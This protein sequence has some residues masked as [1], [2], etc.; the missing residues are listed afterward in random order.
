MA[1]IEWAALVAVLAGLIVAADGGY[2]A[3]FVFGLVLCA[4]ICGAGFGLAMLGIWLEERR[5]R[6]RKDPRR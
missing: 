5:D 4:A 1:R 6:A 3:G 2:L